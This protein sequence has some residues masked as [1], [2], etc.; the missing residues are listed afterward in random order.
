VL[1]VVRVA[2]PSRFEG[3]DLVRYVADGKRP[4]PYAVAAIDGGGTAVRTREWKWNQKALFRLAEDAGETTD[5]SARYPRLADELLQVKRG[6][7]LGDLAVEAPSVKPDPH[8]RERL[9]A[10]GYL[11]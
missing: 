5:V 4:P 7:V 2:V 9:R 11:N 6:L 1:S 3:S 10:L 8:L